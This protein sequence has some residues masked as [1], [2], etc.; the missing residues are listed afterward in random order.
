MKVYMS[1][2]VSIRTACRL[3]SN[4]CG[5]LPVPARFWQLADVDVG[6]EHVRGT[7]KADATGPM[8]VDSVIGP[9]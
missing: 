6:A 5:A 8:M 3:P 1:S 7:G 4:E 2:I 9:T